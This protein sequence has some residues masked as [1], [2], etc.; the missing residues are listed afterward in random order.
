MII[1]KFKVVP[2]PEIKTKINNGQKVPLKEDYAFNDMAYLDSKEA[3]KLFETQADI[4]IKKQCKGI[5]DVGCRHGPILDILYTKG[6]TDFDGFLDI[7][8]LTHL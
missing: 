4:I 3:F 6:Y 7:W 8:D 5:V 1:Q 2:W